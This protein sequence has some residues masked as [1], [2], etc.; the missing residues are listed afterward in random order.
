MKVSREGIQVETYW[1]V[2]EKIYDRPTQEKLSLLNKEPEAKKQLKKLLSSSVSYRLISDVPL[3]VFLSGGIDSSIIAAL[4]T[5]ASPRPINTFSIGFEE[6]DWNEAPYAREVSKALGTEHHEFI[7]SLDEAKALIPQ[8]VDIYDEPFADSSAIP[9]YLLSQLA[10]KHVKVV[11]GGD[12][13]DELFLGY[14]MYQWAERLSKRFW[15]NLRKPIS[16]SLAL[17]KADRYQKASSLFDYNNKQEL[18]SHIFSQEQWLFS[19]RE[20]EGLLVSPLQQRRYQRPLQNRPLNPM[21][22]QALF[23]LGFY[24]PDDLLVKVD[25]ATMRHSLEG[26]VPLLDHRVVEFAINLAPGL[27][28]KNGI[29]KYLLKQVLYDYL[30]EKL[31]DRPKQGF[32]IPL[33]DWL[34][35]DLKYLLEEFLSKSVIEKH[36]LV[37]Y[38]PV[39]QLKNKFLKGQTYYYNRLWTLVVLHQFLRKHF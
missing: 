28:Y 5:E 35:G 32:S 8:L 15:Q 18:L 6:S 7:V 34:Q 11:L 25:R 12:G 2:S 16:R 1:N 27:R 13:G 14:G 19:R 10:A 20:I 31:F 38:E 37:K 24:L 29:T 26:R 21:E 23:D 3:G 33:A 17:F 22:Q 4:A 30:P 39:E 9:T 36:G